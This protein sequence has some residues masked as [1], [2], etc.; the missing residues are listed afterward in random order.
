MGKVNVS[1]AL[2]KG[3]RRGQVQAAALVEPTF[4]A[5]TAAA[6]N[7]LRIKGKGPLRLFLQKGNK[8]NAQPPEELFP[9][10]D[11][12]PIP[13][14]A[15]I[16]V[17]TGED[18]I[19]P[20]GRV[21]GSTGEAN[22]KAAAS[23]LPRPPF[24]PWPAGVEPLEG[25]IPL[26]GPDQDEDAEEKEEEKEEEEEEEEKEVGKVPA[27]P[28]V[29]GSSEEY[30]RVGG[31]A[32]PRLEGCVL[33]LVR[34]AI[35]GCAEFVERMPF[36][37]VV[38]FDYKDSKVGGG[39]LFPNP[40]ASRGRTRLL[41]AVR[42]ECRGLLVRA[43]TGEVVARRFHKFFNLGEIPEAEVGDEVALLATEKCDGS[44]CSPLLLGDE[45]VWASR[46]APSESLSKRGAPYTDYVRGWLSRGFTPLFEWCEPGKPVGVIEHSVPSL[47]LTG[48]RHNITGDYVPREE[49]GA[50]ESGVTVA[51]VV[52]AA[53]QDAA[54]TCDEIRR[55][56]AGWENREGV[57]VTL[58]DGRMFKVKSEWYVSTALAS[59]RGGGDTSAKHL[60][61][62]LRARP[63]LSGVRCGPVWGACLHWQADDVIPACL[64]RLGSS[65]AAVLRE[66]SDAVQGGMTN[67]SA[68]LAQW[69]REVREIAEEAPEGKKRVY[70]MAVALAGAVGW[71]TQTVN[72][73][74]RG[75]D[76]ADCEAEL[77]VQL[78]KLLEAGEVT[79]LGELLQTGAWEEYGEI[80][81]VEDTISAHFD[82]APDKVR[83][84]VLQ[85]YLRAKVANFLGVSDV[86]DDTTVHIP[87][88][89]GPSE[90]KMKGQW[91]MFTK[92]GLVDLR[93]DLQPC[94]KQG[95]TEHYGDQRWALW[96]IQY[97]PSKVC[98]SSSRARQGKDA[99]GTFAG[100]FQRTDTDI[101]FAWLRSAMEQSFARGAL[102]RLGRTYAA[103]R[104]VQ[105]TPPEVRKKV[106]CDLDGVL[107]DFERGIIELTGRST[108]DLGVS[109]MWRHVQKAPA[110]F[111]SLAWCSG[112]KELWDFLSSSGA[113]VSIL[114]GLP[115]GK[116]SK[117][118]ATQKR[119]WVAANLGA[120]I[121]VTTCIGI[122]GQ[123][124]RP[125]CILIDDSERH[126]PSW[127]KKGGIF[128]LWPTDPAEAPRAM[129]QLQA[130]LAKEEDNFAKRLNDAIPDKEVAEVY[131]VPQPRIQFITAE[132]T[133]E[134]GEHLK[135]ARV[136]GVDVEWRPDELRGDGM[137]S[138]AAVLQLAIDGGPVF[139]VD[140][141]GEVDMHPVLEVL[142]SDCVVKVG[143]GIDE[144]LLRLPGVKKAE[145]VC[146]LQSLLQPCFRGLPPLSAAVR[147]V[148]HVSMVKN[149]A[150]QAADWEARPLPDDLL[151][152]AAADAAVAVDMYKRL[153]EA[154]PDDLRCH[155]RTVSV[156]RKERLR[157]GG[158][159][160]NGEPAKDTLWQSPVPFRFESVVVKLDPPAVQL[161]LEKVPPSHPT[162]YADHVTIDFSPSLQRVK[163]VNVGETCEVVVTGVVDTGEVQ[164]VALGARLAGCHITISTNK[165]IPP[166]AAGEALA[167][168]DVLPLDST[169]S[170]QGVYGVVVVGVQGDAVLPTSLPHRV[171]EQVMHLLESPPGSSVKFK[172]HELSAADRH[173]LHLYAEE[174]GLES[175]S[176]GPKTNRRLTMR[177]PRGGVVK[178]EKGDLR[179]ISSAAEL[180][181]EP[182]K[183]GQQGPPTLRHTVTHQPTVDGLLRSHLLVKP[184]V[185]PIDLHGCVGDSGIISWSTPPP[186]VLQ[187]ALEGDID[188]EV[189]LVVV[190]RG[191][192]GSGKS[193]VATGL[194]DKGATVC[195]ADY[196]FERGAGKVKSKGDVYLE[197]FD[198]KLL[199]QAH[200]LCRREFDAA[201]EEGQHVV[202]VD[203]VH[204]RRS[205]YAYYKE[206]AEVHGYTCVVLELVTSDESLIYGTL[207]RGVHHVPIPVVREMFQ[208][209]EVDPDAYRLAPYST[210]AS[211][212]HTELHDGLGLWRWLSS[213]RF[214][215]FSNKRESTHLSWPVEWPSRRP[216]THISIPSDRRDEFLERF[217]TEQ[218]D[219][220]YIV[221]L[222]GDVFRLFFDIDL[223]DSLPFADLL[224]VCHTVQHTLHTMYPSL[225]PP[226]AVVTGAGRQGEGDSDH[227]G[228]HLHF[229]GIIVDA[230]RAVK[231]REAVVERLLDSHPTTDWRAAVDEAV[232]TFNRS[233]RM[234]GSRKVHK[235]YDVGRVYS[236]VVALDEAGKQDIETM[237]SFHADR[238]ALLRAVSIHADGEKVTPGWTD[239]ATS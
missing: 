106:Y 171:K 26:P 23:R 28:C 161:L 233:L 137:K 236:L 90:G 123:Y 43:S 211:P 71:R 150:L 24:W 69:G 4:D 169:V 179:V 93:V 51:P 189:R 204:A 113:D 64:Q 141:I 217:A 138:P 200:A 120:D 86:Q 16:L 142:E 146:D 12:L 88:N 75:H 202:V 73:Y 15:V 144:D 68:A 98:K 50:E 181:K 126:R 187:Q 228:Y 118:A 58:R 10:P 163:A 139:V 210:T 209:W 81:C 135:T 94:R 140:M 44:L 5:I 205:G 107:C 180:D 56:V 174:V 132:Q 164:A 39:H 109:A 21:A 124:S 85:T 131:T 95:R 157:V 239:G 82:P 41:H 238:V 36:P 235:G 72:S 166:K 35:A 208:S 54:L 114:T 103:A 47:V 232:F 19:L 156:A 130:L 101:P 152:Y 198:E 42:R 183:K 99:A 32:Y 223:D 186:L 20:D 62:L 8:K 151:Q 184:V 84:H 225:P 78:A 112:G 218:D 80:P 27:V 122:K 153:H 2:N 191:L 31:G 55:E 207:R 1:F 237:D 89:Y 176:E 116:L 60:L 97:G 18:A 195:S 30:R 155:L 76:P 159:E 13:P 79:A 77:R 199:P 147:R 125:G 162:V 17:S 83:D 185:E 129:G 167:T 74:L 40:A 220:L 9:S 230:P 127:E 37:D 234:V 133:A 219:P 117:E 216:A 48:I 170:L 168:G 143:F 61:E 49:W 213:N 65:D 92:D 193:T 29:A 229:P 154:V 201:L 52:F 194:R 121:E 63:T 59:K 172:A 110:F 34:E 128:F 11:P 91:E 190:L 46:T 6:C 136:I 227:A 145:A 102:M 53:P 96:S 108:S 111:R 25:T 215:H 45:V 115:A 160:V 149:K 57:V 22:V 188:E 214:V 203:N 177:V 196:F 67:L 3:K 224:A 66:F 100:V 182:K 158:R 192:P 38:A 212:Q 134:L 33:P 7:K 70:A 231:I 226:P 173:A 206:Q 197:C 165:G 105:S 104:P 14:G 222:A 178:R 87:S 119:D 175:F 221:E 148:L